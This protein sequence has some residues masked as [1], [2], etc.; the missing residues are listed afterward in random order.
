[1]KVADEAY[2]LLSSSNEALDAIGDTLQKAK[3]K[4]AELKALRDNASG[5]KLI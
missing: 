4:I 5:T 3:E 2:K 1:M